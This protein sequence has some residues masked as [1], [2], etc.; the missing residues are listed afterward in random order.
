LS[1]L[2][3]LT[4]GGEGIGYGHISRCSAIAAEYERRGYDSELIVD[5]YGEGADTFAFRKMRW[6]TGKVDSS[7]N[8]VLVDSYKASL[9]E[10]KRLKQYFNQVFVLDDFGRFYD[11][12]ADLIINPNVYAT[13]IP[14]TANF[15]GGKDYIILRDAFTS[16]DGKREITGNVKTVLVTIGGSDYRNLVPLFADAFR[17]VN[18][19]FNFLCSNND[20]ALQMADT[21]KAHTNFRF[22]GY[23]SAVEM[24]DR[25]METD[26]AIS[27]CGQTLHELAFLGIPTVGICID[28]D[29]EYN[30]DSYLEAGVLFDRVY[31]NDASL[32][33]KLK[34]ALK[35]MEPVVV[36]QKLSKEGI[37]LVDGQG[38]S[39]IVDSTCAYATT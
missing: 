12:G 34:S 28:N 25:M 23:L 24:R 26:V 11:Y 38:I 27:A 2:L 29:Q 30:G 13:R 17:D 5:W 33:D 36:R 7:F 20:Y 19:D 3:I 35:S 15:V 21:Y 32:A 10:I 31:W 18:L 16:F 9:E 8:A 4:E 37:A 1:S 6:R 22:Y 14:Y 39:R